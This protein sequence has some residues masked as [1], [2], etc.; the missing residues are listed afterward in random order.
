MVISS[1]AADKGKVYVGGW[2]GRLYAL[3]AANG[4]LIW[5]YS[6]GGAV[7]SSPAVANGIVY[8]GSWD[9]R[10][11]ALNASTGV[12]PRLSTPHFFL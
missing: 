7:D 5:R 4:G 2:D 11:Y 6:T 12:I 8:I 3:D 9:G 1:P 10:V